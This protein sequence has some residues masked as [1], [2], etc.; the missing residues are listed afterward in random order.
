MVTESSFTLQ[1]QRHIF[2]YLG[3]VIEWVLDLIVTAMTLKKMGTI[4]T[5]GGVH[6]VTAL[7]NKKY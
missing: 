2:H 1:R 6:I 3:G 4:A 5:D 7:E